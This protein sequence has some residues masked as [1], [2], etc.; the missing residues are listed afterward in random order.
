MLV[1]PSSAEDTSARHDDLATPWLDH[2]SDRSIAT[3]VVEDVSEVRVTSRPNDTSSRTCDLR[4]LR[5][6]WSRGWWCRLRRRWWCRLGLGRRLRRRLRL[7]RGLRRGF[8]CRCRID[9]VVADVG[10]LTAVV[11][12]SRCFDVLS[13]G[14][15]TIGRELASVA[16][17]SLETDD[18]ACLEDDG[19][20]TRVGLGA[21]IRALTGLRGWCGPRAAA[22]SDGSS[23]HESQ[24]QSDTLHA[25]PLCYWIPTVRKRGS[26]L[27]SHGPCAMCE[28]SM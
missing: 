27:F 4:R 2:E 17:A 1:S 18:Q 15:R 22:A 23:E 16:I 14:R 21:T 9:D 10:H 13:D 5:R 3:P 11:Q 24:E 6:R 19:P 25:F 8:W 12:Q 28:M 26:V 7:R 20:I